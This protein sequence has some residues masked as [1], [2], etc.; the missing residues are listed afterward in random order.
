MRGDDDT[1]IGGNEVRAPL[2]LGGDQA[3]EHAA[4]AAAVNATNRMRLVFASGRGPT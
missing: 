3:L 1:S 2:P 4:K